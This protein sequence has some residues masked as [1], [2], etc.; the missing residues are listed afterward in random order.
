MDYQTV[1]LIIIGTELTRGII[2]DKHGQVIS[3]ELSHLGYSVQKIIIVPDDGSIQG[4]L[5]DCI[6][7]SDV[8]LVTGGLGPTSDD[9]TRKAIADAAAVALVKNEAAYAWLYAKVG[10]RIHGANEIQTMFPSGFDP[11]PNPNGTAQG[12]WGVIPEGNR[13]VVCISMPGPPR[14]MDPM[15][16]DYVLPYLGKLRGHEDLSRDEYSSFLVAESKLEELCQKAAVP[17]VSWGDR[18]QDFR[19]SLYLTG[20]APKRQEFAR[21]LRNLMGSELLVDGD[22]EAVSLLDDRLVSDKLTICCA[23]S[24]TGGLL[25]KLLTD[26]AGSSDWFWGSLVTYANEAKHAVLGV[27]EDILS[28]Y[29]AVSGECAIAMAEEAL[30][31]SGASLAISTTGFAGP[32]GEQV[33]LVWFGFARAGQASQAVKLEFSS[34]GRESIRRRASVAACLLAIRYLD[35]T[36]LLDTTNAWQYI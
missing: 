30:G 35:G 3:T 14:E 13:Q 7:Q 34:Y 8:V 2:G 5:G 33:G 16:F 12:F 31:K 32:T 36:R 19:I 22:V 27:G 18:F 25:G 23:E 11:I 26:R 15:F 20:D 6:G 21:K 17:G 4:V 10:E 28:T 1:S 24:C 9:M 29:G